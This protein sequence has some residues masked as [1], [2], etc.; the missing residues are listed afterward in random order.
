MTIL[1]H[2]SL[3][4]GD[5]RVSGNVGSRNKMNNELIY[6]QRI[7]N[8]ESRSEYFPHDP[9]GVKQNNKLI[10]EQGLTNGDLRSEYLLLIRQLA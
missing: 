8:V 2:H 1:D 9:E 6:E 10:S 3:G 7:M 4:E 5:Y